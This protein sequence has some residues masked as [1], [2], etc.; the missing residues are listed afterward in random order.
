MQRVAGELQQVG[1]GDVGA[2]GRKQHEEEDEV[3]KVQQQQV[4]LVHVPAAADLEQ[5]AQH[6]KEHVAHHVVQVVVVVVD[7]EKI[8]GHDGV[9]DSARKHH[10]VEQ[11]EDEA[12]KQQKSVGTHGGT[13]TRVAATYR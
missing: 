6:R 5:E 12:S 7:A 9:E 3:E 10:R 13:K 8:N 4:D 1:V 11:H 2:A